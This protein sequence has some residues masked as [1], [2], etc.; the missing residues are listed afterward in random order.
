MSS[1]AQFLSASSAAERL[2][3]STKAL[4]L[5]EQRGLLAPDRTAAG[6]RMYGPDEMVRA[7][8]I[9]A[10]RALGLSLLQV[11]RVLEGDPQSLEL[12]LAAHEATLEGEFANS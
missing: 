6:Y 9:V 5:Y 1:S 3:V 7:A 2:G 8:E 10:L 12:A 11:A 4:R